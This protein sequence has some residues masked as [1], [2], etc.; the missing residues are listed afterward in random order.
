MKISRI[1]RT[2]LAVPAVLALPLSMVACADKDDDATTYTVAATD[3]SCDVSSYDA[4]TGNNNFEVTNTGK[5]ITE[6]YVYTDGGRVVGEVENIGPGAT[7]K[8]LVSIPEAGTYRTTCKPGMVGEGISHDLTVTGD[9]VDLAEG[10]DKLTAAVEGYLRYVRSQTTALQESVGTFTDAIQAGDV[11]TAKSLFA[12]TRTYYERIEPIAESF[13]DDLDPRI[14][15]REA[16]LEDG[17]KWTGFHKIEKALWVDGKITD[18]TRKDADQLVADVRELV[19]GVN[20][21]DF[22]V[23]PDLI[24]NGAH[25]LLDE[26]STSKITG[27]E[28]TF[29]HTDLWDFQANLDGSKAAVAAL[30]ESIDEKDPNLLADINAKFDSVQQLLDTY[31]EG[32]GFISYDKVSEND[33]KKLSTALDQLNEQVSKVTGVVTGA[34]AN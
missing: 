25:G 13:P 1:S 32:D 15:L 18:E 4:R 22:T 10:D 29:S 20:A 17:Q 31:R 9:A 12:P 34:E 21:G 7:R 26:I 27:E 14:D 16:D 11:N 3:D 23:A 8:L 2:A 30:E 6:F 33:R 19:D 28:D 5:K 24:A